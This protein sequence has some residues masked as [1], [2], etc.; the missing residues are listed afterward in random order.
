MYDA[1]NF[2]AFLLFFFSS[3][4][5]ADLLSSRA[6]PLLSGLW[7]LSRRLILTAALFL[8]YFAKTTTATSQVRISSSFVT[9]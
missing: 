3:Q 6:F 2:S 1:S 7:Q 9:V 5:L 8:T 4:I